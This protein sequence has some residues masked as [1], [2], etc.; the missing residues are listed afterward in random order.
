MNQADHRRL[1]PW[2]MLTAALLT[3]SLLF[4]ATG[5]GRH[6]HWL[7][8]QEK[9]P[10]A[11]ST[12]TPALPAPPP[13]EA[14]ANTWKQPVFS[15]DRK[16]D[17]QMSIASETQLLQGF[18]LTGVI[19]TDT[20]QLALLKDSHGKALSLARGKALPNGWKLER[21]EPD[22]VLFTAGDRQHLLPLS[23]EK[24]PLGPA[25][26]APPPTEVQPMSPG[27]TSSK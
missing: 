26:Q 9:K 24:A 18:T 23:I 7:P 27:Q 19:V 15:P 10:Q 5:V 11:V 8:S 22:E 12:N 25:S 6:V 1:T 14:Y 3:A 4:F 20:L 13:L 17:Q 2:L 21:V 16:P